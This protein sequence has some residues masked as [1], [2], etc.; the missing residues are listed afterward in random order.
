MRLF[1]GNAINVF[2]DASTK[3]IK[4]DKGKEITVVCPAFITTM[5][6]AIL[7]YGSK[8]FYDQ[9]N[10]FGE[11][12]AL[13]MGINSL[14]KY[15]DTEL[16]LNVFSDSEWSVNALTMWLYKWYVNG[17][18]QFQLITGSKTSVRHQDVMIDI[19]QMIVNANVH[20]SIFHI[21]GHTNKNSVKSM[22]KFN[23]YFYK[24]NNL[25]G[26]IPAE[27]L[28]EMA[29]FNDLVDN[30]SRDTLKKII[31]KFDPKMFQRPRRPGFYWF[32]NPIQMKQYVQLVNQ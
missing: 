18:N 2:T 12:F 30:M 7:E 24:R 22:L 8:V 26:Q 32:P 9:T 17:Y 13:G 11:L 16:F 21:L 3:T 28:Q 6:G 14:L 27:Y 19:I 31:Q 5:G 20:I 25:R 29:G 23:S 4:D 1:Y 15:S 10:N